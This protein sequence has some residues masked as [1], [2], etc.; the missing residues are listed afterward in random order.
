ME[1][2]G[3]AN[4]K[5]KSSGSLGTIYA[6]NGVLIPGAS[7]SWT[8]SG[9]T[10]NSNPTDFN[11]T[12]YKKLMDYYDFASGSKPQTITLSGIPNG[13]YI[14]YVYSQD[15]KTTGKPDIDS[16]GNHH[17]GVQTLN[18]SVAGQTGSA[19]S[20]PNATTFTEN[21]NY[22]KI[23]NITM[24]GNQLVIN[25]SSGSP[26]AG[27]LGVINGFQLLDPP[28]SPGAVPEPSSIAYIG[29]GAALAG[30]V[31]MRNRRNAA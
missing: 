12:D 19:T 31:R 8:S 28:A 13:N 3:L 15:E 4:D 16:N 27:G 18:I 20:D 24:S 7:V 29:I 10:F 22:I 25:Y 23:N 6:S 17:G 5:K 26:T 1:W 30:F 11:S 2:T 21:K 9:D 14:L